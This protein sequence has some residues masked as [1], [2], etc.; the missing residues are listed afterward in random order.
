MNKPD[1]V[2]HYEEMLAAG[3]NIYLDPVEI[4]EI[5]HYYAEGNEIDKMIPLVQLGRTLHPANEMVQAAEAELALNLNEFER[6][7]KLLEPIFDDQ[8]MFH[9]VLRSACY[10]GLRNREKALED[11]HV[12]LQLAE[13][14]TR[15]MR[16]FVAYDLGL[17]FSNAFLFEDAIPFLLASEDAEP[18]DVRNLFCLANCY[19]GLGE[20]EMVLR[21]ADRCIEVDPYY[22]D[23][24]LLRASAYFEKEEVEKALDCYDY[25]LAIEPDSIDVK[26]Y[27]A[28]IYGRTER[29]AEAEELLNEVEGKVVEPLQRADV[30]I[31]QARIAWDKDRDKEKAADYAWR[32]VKAC[33]SEANSILRA[34]MLLQEM[35]LYED[36]K[37]VY[38][39]VYQL[40][41]NNEDALQHLADIYMR[42]EKPEESVRYYEELAALRPQDEPLHVL[43]AIALLS[44]EESYRS[45]AVLQDYLKRSHGL[46][47]W[48]VYVVLT[49][50]AFYAKEQGLMLEYLNIAYGRAPKATTDM[51]QSM[52]PDLHKMLEENEFFKNANT[53][54]LY[55]L[56]RREVLAEI[57]AEHKGSIKPESTEKIKKMDIEEA[58]EE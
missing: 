19:K 16:A 37:V 57:E 40:D 53:E 5:F 27:K 54:R 29:Y 18:D 30:N 41:K 48:Q 14:D 56:I 36:A 34:A 39:Q 10:A 47:A 15:Q 33:P 38:K 6:C 20:T 52:A 31:M 12:A 42:L 26:L 49:V 11:A 58:K 21:Y 8:Q 25:A 28:I 4:D 50:A 46:P 22:L 1:C 45:I 7:M 23:A 2:I 3:T 35:E 24:W 17:G 9:Y 32:S 43:W 51:L 44:I 55:D 13:N